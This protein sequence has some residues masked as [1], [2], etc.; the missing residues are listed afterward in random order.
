M[1]KRRTAFVVLAICLALIADSSGQSQRP[2]QRSRESVQPPISETANPAQPPASDQRGT[3]QSPVIVKVLPSDD[4]KQK[5][6]TEAKR[7]EQKT[8]NDENLALFWATIALAFI[9]TLQLFVFGWQGIQL[10]RT[11]DLANR[12]FIAT[13][14]P[15]LKVR[16]IFVAGFHERFPN[17]P[18]MAGE[19]LNA[20]LEIVNIGGTR[21]T[22]VWSR[23]RIY[24]GEQHY[25]LVPHYVPPHALAPSAVT[26]DGGQRLSFELVDRIPKD[27]APEG[28]L[29]R[30]RWGQ[31]D[32]HMFVIG[33]IRYADGNGSIRY[34]GFCREMRSY[35][36]FRAVDD[37][38]YEYED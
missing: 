5:A 24:F 12:E 1:L 36:R 2:P 13:H 16:R 8:T 33:E 15:R 30:P 3:E 4:E 26:L 18:L 19:E 9:A 34:L 11:V 7:E 28:A 38:D 17:A 37:P 35:G 21:G 22:I 6:A 20:S 10:N 32:W 25:S 23:Y 27:A 14:R 31:D 29:I